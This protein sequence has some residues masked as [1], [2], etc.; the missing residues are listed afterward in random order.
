MKFR[1]NHIE[2]VGYYLLVTKFWWLTWKKVGKH[3]TGF[4][5]YPENDINHP[6]N[7]IAEAKDRC[8]KYKVWLITLEKRANFYEI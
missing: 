6:M 4:G 2:G 1:I 7:N 3:T 5:L 8:R